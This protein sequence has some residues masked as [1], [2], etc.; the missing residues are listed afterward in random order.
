M[1]VP[2]LIAR[3]YEDLG[4]LAAASGDEPQAQEWRTAAER[5]RQEQQEPEK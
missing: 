5:A 1:Q 3:S 4:E 2:E